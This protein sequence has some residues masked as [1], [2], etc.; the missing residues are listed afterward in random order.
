MTEMINAGAESYAVWLQARMDERG[1][2]QRQ[3]GKL[4]RP[5]SPET[6]RR[7][8]R[9]YL[10]GMIPTERSR[11]SIAHALGTSDLGPDDTAEDD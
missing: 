5:D 4:L 11:Q 3:L 6:A 10:K 2:T 8:V 7:A 9:R 1:L